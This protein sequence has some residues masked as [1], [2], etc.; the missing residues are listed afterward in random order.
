MIKSEAPPKE[1]SSPPPFSISRL[2]MSTP[3]TS[4]PLPLDVPIVVQ[5]HGSAAAASPSLPPWSCP[6]CATA[7]PLGAAA[8]APHPWPSPPGA[9]SHSRGGPPRAR[10]NLIDDTAG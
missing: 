5:P 6:P 10:K 8:A 7:C 9:A 1:S 4:S 3:P 2:L